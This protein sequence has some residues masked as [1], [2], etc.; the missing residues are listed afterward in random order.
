MYYPQ[1]HAESQLLELKIV[2][3]MENDLSVFCILHMSL[4]E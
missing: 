4:S 1:G 3:Q 2:T